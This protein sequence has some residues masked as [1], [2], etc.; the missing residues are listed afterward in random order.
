MDQNTWNL[1]FGWIS[2]K[3]CLLPEGCPPP[4]EGVAVYAVLLF[5]VAGGAYWLYNN[6]E[7]L[8]W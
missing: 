8:P 3:K 2:G 7:Q 4:A 1:L 5:V 6:W